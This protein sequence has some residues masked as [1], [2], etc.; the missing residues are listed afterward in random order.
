MHPLFNRFNTEPQFPGDLSIFHPINAVHEEYFAASFRQFADGLLQVLMKLLTFQQVFR[1]FGVVLPL[2]S[3]LK[4][5]LNLPVLPVIEKKVVGY[6]IQQVQYGFFPDGFPLFPKLEKG[7][8]GKIFRQCHVA[9]FIVAKIPDL[10]V[11][12]V[13]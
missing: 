1:T 8:L 11:V 13:K 4:P 7:F 6:G 9:T 3:L 2:R 10:G 12:L 5:E